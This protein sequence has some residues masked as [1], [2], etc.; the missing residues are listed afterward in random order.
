MV[1]V[2]TIGLGAIPPLAKICRIF[3]TGLLT[4]VNTGLDNL[5]HIPEACFDLQG[6][7]FCSQLKR[8]EVSH[9]YTSLI[10]ARPACQM[11]FILQVEVTTSTQAC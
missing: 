3:G 2:G 11:D 6:N 9:T 5:F 10:N 7:E 1:V 8:L 4:I